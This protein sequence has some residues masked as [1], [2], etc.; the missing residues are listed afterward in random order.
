MTEK[1]NLLK[2][3]ELIELNEVYSNLPG[4]LLKDL[5]FKKK[6]KIESSLSLKP[7]IKA[8]E[9]ANSCNNLNELYQAVAA[10]KDLSITKTAQNVVFSDGNPLA[11]IMAIGEAPG[12]N[13]DEQ[14]IPFCGA[15]GQLLDQIFASIGLSRKENIYI[16]NSVFWRPPGNRKPTDEE[17]ITCLP[18]LEKH[19]AL[20]NPKLIILVGSTAAQALL[21]SS[22]TISRMRGKFLAYN[23][24]YLASEIATMV[25]FHPSYLFRQPLQKKQVWL[26]MIAIRKMLDESGVL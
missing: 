5:N 16:T 19:I 12:A 2:F 1:S 26:D 20:I 22:E 15:S 23:N 9:L 18:F 25:I 10:F 7:A 6:K 8:R 13:E 24:S 4:E 11:K 14:G 3:Y 21:N 17:I